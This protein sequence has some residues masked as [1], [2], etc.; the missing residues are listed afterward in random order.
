VEQTGE[1]VEV[2]VEGEVAAILEPV[3]READS[4]THRADWEWRRRLAEKITKHWEGEVDAVSAVDE[5]R[6]DL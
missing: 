4:E 2:S 1:S 5:R 6:R 3:V